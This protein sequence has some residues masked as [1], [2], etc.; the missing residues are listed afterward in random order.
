[1]MTS[2]PTPKVRGLYAKIMLL[3]GSIFAVALLAILGLVYYTETWEIHYVTC[4]QCTPVPNP[5]SADTPNNELTLWVA[6]DLWQQRRNAL[7]RV[8]G[9]SLVALSLIVFYAVRRLVMRPLQIIQQGVVAIAQGNLDHRLTVQTGDE[10]ALLAAEF[11]RM[12][13]Q[14]RASY[15]EVA[16]ERSKLIAAIEH[17]RDA[18]WISDAHQRI[19]RV[20]PALE[21]LTGRP[22][23]AL[24]G[25]NCHAL[26]GIRTVNGG[27]MCEF[28]C[29][30]LKGS[31]PHGA[32]EGYL[33]AA[34][35]K[36][37]WVEIGYGCVTNTAGQVTEVIHIVH[38]LTER[39]EIERLKDEFLAMVSHELRTPLH[40]IKGFATTLLQTDVTWDQ[41]TQRDFL[42]SINNEADRLTSLIE[43]ILHL[44][45]LEAGAAPL[46]KEWCA[47]D[48]LVEGAVTRRRI[49]ATR[50]RLR[51][52]LTDNLPPLF[53]DSRQL[54]NVLINLIENAANYS[55]PGT[56]IDVQAE[57]IATEITFSI[58][59]Y[60][61]GIPPTHLKA[62]FD[63]FYRVNEQEYGGVGAGLGLAIC[64][65][66]VEAHGGRI[67]AE[68][69]LGVGS[70][71]YFT[72]PLQS[73]Q[74]VEEEQAHEEDTHPVGG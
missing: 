60:G 30:L 56:P 25:Q 69:T 9:G 39:K 58:A 6:D 16:G 68:S 4:S 10:L 8:V 41:A 64:K 31:A 32:I 62:I 59:D 28:A 38:D 12:T 42:E 53:V 71:F 66:I 24:L 35:G 65:R 15:D 2:Q 55:E 54:E 61:R 3:V 52:H 18:I 45:R 20:N 14:L 29:P 11:N 48:D 27:L 13:Q 40:H 49:A 46:A 43:K 70:C 51:L 22:R 72:L 57:V 74:Q 47:L 44:S 34:S 23:A 36:E 50:P 17:S 67:W 19:V 7:L 33:P 26:M 5:Q 37:A 73:N 1:M 63:R 21:R